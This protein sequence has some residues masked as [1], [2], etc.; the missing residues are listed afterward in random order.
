MI[1]FPE[2][3]LRPHQKVIGILS[4]RST[5][6]PSGTTVVTTALIIAGSACS[7][8]HRHERKIKHRITEMKFH[9]SKEIHLQPL[10]HTLVIMLEE[11]NTPLLNYTIQE[12]V[13][14]DQSFNLR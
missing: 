7:R 12:N 5:K 2:L 3:L 9:P 8:S 1:H 13:V 10:T 4:V 14:L 11:V 6:I